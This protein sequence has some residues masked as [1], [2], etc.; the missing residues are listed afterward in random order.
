LKANTTG[1]DLQPVP[2][3][4]LEAQIKSAASTF[5]L[6]NDQT[7]NLEPNNQPRLMVLLSAQQ[8]Q[9]KPHAA[10]AVAHLVLSSLPPD[11]V[12]HVD[13]D[14][15]PAGASTAQLQLRAGVH[16]IYLSRPH[17]EDSP[18]KAVQLQ[19]GATVKISAD[20]F[21]LQPQGALSFKITPS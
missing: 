16:K 11:S 7:L 9:A 2:P 1:Q 13:G 17:F 4:G 5:T 14:S 6:S 15:Q 20:D 19:P 8:D 10:N 21:P 3:E 12:V 18:A